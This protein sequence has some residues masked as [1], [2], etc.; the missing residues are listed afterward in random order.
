MVRNLRIGGGKFGGQMR[1][2]IVFSSSFCCCCLLAHLLLVKKL[3]RF[4][5]III[6]QRQL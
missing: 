5:C 4:E 1:Y 6:Q 2:S 3:H